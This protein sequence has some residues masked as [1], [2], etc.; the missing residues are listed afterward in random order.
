MLVGHDMVHLLL[1]PVAAIGNRD[2]WCLCNTNRL[3]FALGRL[4]H[5]LEVTEVRGARAHLGRE[6]DLLL[7]DYGLDV[8]ALGVASR[9][10]HIP[11]V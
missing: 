2:P 3:E 7:G 11:R 4:D 8:V 1:I 9:S 6:H 5:R 10:L